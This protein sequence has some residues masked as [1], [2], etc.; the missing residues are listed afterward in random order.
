MF[1]KCSFHLVVKSWFCHCVAQGQ[2][3]PKQL[4][5][6]SSKLKEF[7]ADHFKFGEN[8]RKFSKRGRKHC[9]KKETAC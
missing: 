1:S 8:D 7:A 2:S 6:E 9:G 3:L 5:L 4:S